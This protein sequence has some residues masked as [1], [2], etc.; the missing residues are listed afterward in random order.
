MSRVHF[1]PRSLTIGFVLTAILVVVF[2]LAVAAQDPNNGEQ[3]APEAEQVGPVLES[4]GTVEEELTNDP[5][6]AQHQTDPLS[7]G[8]SGTTSGEVTVV[9]EVELLDAPESPDLLQYFTRYS[10][11]VFVPY[12]DDMTY[13][14]Y[15]GGC[16]YRTGGTAFMDHTLQLPEGAEIDYLRIYFYDNDAS[17]DAN[18]ILFA[19]DDVGN[20]IQIAQAYS[21]G[22]PGWSSAGSGFFSYIVDNLNQSLSLRL[23][24][25]SGSNSNLVICSVRIRYQYTLAL[26]SMPLILKEATP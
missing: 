26:R 3:V 9:E 11:N 23:G 1:S 25:G 17:N 21:S 19:Y 18:S 7:N 5:A 8:E 20:Y 13:N 10:A 12:D 2:T 16:R 22:T 14:Y 4:A 15:G 6:Q 24:F